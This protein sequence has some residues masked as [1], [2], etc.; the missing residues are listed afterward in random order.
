MSFETREQEDVSMVRSDGKLG[1]EFKS[2]DVKQK[3]LDFVK[4]SNDPY[5]EHFIAI[6]END[7]VIP[8]D[9][10]DFMA[11]LDRKGITPASIPNKMR[12]DYMV[13]FQNN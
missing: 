13:A 7:G 4:K 11:M 12:A 9:N 10:P 8:T 2:Q 6:I 3:F 5:M 1:V